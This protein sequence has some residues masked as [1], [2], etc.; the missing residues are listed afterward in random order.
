MPKAP[1]GPVVGHIRRLVP[2]P[3]VERL[4]DGQLLDRFTGEHEE[5]AFA[6]LLRRHG[7]MVLHVCRR[8]LHQVHDAEDA[9]QATFLLLARKAASIRKQESVASWLH[10]VAYRLAVRAKAQRARR[11]TR[12]QQA[13]AMHKPGPDL[14]IAWRE[15]QTVLDEELQRLPEKYRT[16]LVLCY[17]EGLT[18]EA[19]ARQLGWPLGTVTGRLARARTMLRTRLARRGLALSGG[20]FAATLAANTAAASLP[21]TLM[22]PTLTAA[23]QFAA[24]KAAAA[25]VAAP[26]A[27]LVEKA[28]LATK[29]KLVTVLLLAA[30]L[31]VGGASLF[32]RPTPP[33]EEAPPAQVRAAPEKPA[34]A[35]PREE[36]D[37]VVAAGRVLGPDGQPA[38]GARLYLAYFTTKK[39]EPKVR[40]RTGEDG[41]FRFT[42]AKAAI[43][44]PGWRKDAWRGATVVAVA[45]GCGPD[46]A[47]AD[48]VA[49]GEVTLRL[50]RD[51]CPV[52]GRVLDLEGRPV[53]GVTVRRQ[54]IVTTPAEDL[55]PVLAAWKQGADRA[56]HEAG[57][58]LGS[59]DM[60]DLDGTTTTDKDG[61]FRLGGM[62]RERAVSVSLEGPTIEHKT[63]Y[64]LP[65][66]EAEIKALAHRVRK[67]MDAPFAGPAVCSSTFEHVANP[68]RPV[69]GTVR[70]QR[71]GKPLAGVWINAAAAEGWWGDHTRTQTDEQ[72]RYRLLGLRKAALRLMAGTRTELGYL[73]AAKPV[74]DRDGL[75]PITVDFELVRGVVVQGRLTDKKTGKPVRGSLCYVPLVG[76]PYYGKIHGGRRYEFLGMSHGVDADGRFRFIVM[77]GLGAVLARHGNTEMGDNPYL[78]VHL[79]AEDRKQPYA[80]ENDGFGEH[81]LAA[82]GSLSGVTT[83]DDKNAYRVIDPP[84]DAESVT[85]DLQFDP[86]ETRTGSVL[87]PDGKPLAGASVAGL[88]DVWQKR[89]TLPAATFT[90]T[91]LNP[92]HPRTLIFYHEERKLAAHVVLRGDEKEPVSV[93]LQ[94]VGTLTGRVVDPEGKPVEGAKVRLE[95]RDAAGKRMRLGFGHSGQTDAAGRFTFADV[96]AGPRFVLRASKGGENGGLYYE[97]RAGEHGPVRPGATTDVNDLKVKAE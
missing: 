67:T 9:F 34:D 40:A 69:V 47:S 36:G 57:K 76:N 33:A 66:P 15:L 96:H 2:P 16:P 78:Q 35:P 20:A 70:D 60:L 87:D 64:V 80:A 52:V 4:T 43:D 77:P 30:G 23:V 8:I 55:S 56:L 37:T 59:L 92:Q 18:H 82:D 42:F 79:T 38:V 24:G 48:Q 49:Q 27:A 74:A 89:Q 61:R 28:M 93:R 14:E 13:A 26:V 95:Y 32:A 86:G 31:L 51:E 88:T 63:L 41:R 71:T 85:C 58:S 11:H 3:D 46:W 68:S 53:A 54:S 44:E 5:T 90:A 29:T 81:L 84:A 12:E 17:L 21:T 22:Q 94:P 39:A 7:P 50:V 65:R 75:D 62:G 73:P 45:D 97:S 91:A 83:L 10:G 6:A 72:G 1:L 19:A 25:I